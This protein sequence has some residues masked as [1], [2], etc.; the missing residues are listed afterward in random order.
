MELR[1]L[2]YFVGVADCSGFSRAA[3]NLRL[4]QPALSRQIKSLE[5]ELRIRLFDRLGRRS[6]LTAAGAEILQR[7][8]AVLQE[9]ESIK[10]WAHELAGGSR[11]LLRLGATPHSYESFVA[12][13]LARLRHANSSIEVNLVEDGAANLLDAVRTGAINL[14]VVSLPSNTGLQGRPLFPFGLIAVFPRNH[15]LAGRREI[16]VHE[17]AGNGLLLMHRSFLTRQLFEQACQNTGMRSEILLESSSARSLVTLVEY[18]HGVAIVPSTLK[19]AWS[20]YR[21]SVIQLSGK[22]IGLWMSV[23]WN[24]R[25]Y[26]SPA[27]KLFVELAFDFTPTVSR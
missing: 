18:G 7:A 12:S 1:D 9:T 10:S 27:A 14:A 4:S 13:L 19:L 20:R 17:L 6:V 8:R 16:E 11:G 26:Q 2:R 21:T 24:E 3:E 23:I 5:S 25:L 22:P 15:R